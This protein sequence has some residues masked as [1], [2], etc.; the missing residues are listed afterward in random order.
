MKLHLPNS[1][2]IGNIDTFL[3]KIDTSNGELEISSHKDWVSVHP[4]VSCM[5]TSLGLKM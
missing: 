3:K 5:V 4:V 1:V 2:W